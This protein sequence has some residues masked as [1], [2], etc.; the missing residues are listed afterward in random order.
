MHFIL[1]YAFFTLKPEAKMNLVVRYKQGSENL[2]VSRENNADYIINIPLN[3]FSTDFTVSRSN[4]QSE[5]WDFVLI[6]AYLLI[7][8]FK[9]SQRV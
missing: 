9:L 7:I 1:N 5:A 4:N 2:T 8:G 6:A 3:S